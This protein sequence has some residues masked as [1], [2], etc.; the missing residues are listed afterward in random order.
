MESVVR[1]M[2]HHWVDTG[3]VDLTMRPPYEDLPAQTILLDSLGTHHQGAGVESHP[4]A[5]LRVFRGSFVS[6]LTTYQAMLAKER[7][8]HD[9]SGRAEFKHTCSEGPVE[10]L[11]ARLL[12]L[13]DRLTA[14]NLFIPR[15]P[16]LPPFKELEHLELHCIDFNGVEQSLTGLHSLKTLFL[17]CEYFE[18][19]LPKLRLKRLSKLRHVLLDDVFP[20]Q[21]SLPRGCR[22]DIKGE[23]VVLDPGSSKSKLYWM[24]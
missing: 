7:H 3:S 17:S 18:A 21:L 12:P 5:A 13:M 16:R 2:L 8:R 24:R 23:A 14:L 6:D 20:A 9:G 19:L 15:V 10:R 22:L 1:W 4:P 11:C